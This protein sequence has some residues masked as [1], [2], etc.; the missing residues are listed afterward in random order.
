MESDELQVV[1]FDVTAQDC[2]S[3]SSLDRVRGIVPS[4]VAVLQHWSSGLP[5][6]LLAV[7]CEEGEVYLIRHALVSE[8][9]MA[10]RVDLD[11]FFANE[12]LPPDCAAVA[13]RHVA[14]GV[15]EHMR[16]CNF[17]YFPHEFFAVGYAAGPVVVYRVKGSAGRVLTK[18]HVVPEQS[19]PLALH[20]VT[21]HRLV[22]A[23]P[24]RV[25][26]IEISV[27]NELVEAHVVSSKSF[28]GSSFLWLG[29]R[30]HL[31]SFALHNAVNGAV[32]LRS[33]AHAERQFEF[34]AP[35]VIIGASAN[36]P[37]HVLA[38]DVSLVSSDF[39]AV[40]VAGKDGRVVRAHAFGA[41]PRLLREAL[42]AGRM[43][44]EPPLSHALCK[45]A[46]AA[47]F[48]GL[49]AIAGATDDEAAESIME[50]CLEKD[51][52]GVLQDVFH[53]DGVSAR[54]THV[55][56]WTR[57][58]AAALLDPPAHPAPVA[59]ADTPVA[60][61]EAKLALLGS[62]YRLQEFL[63]ETTQGLGEP[64]RLEAERAAGKTLAHALRL[65]VV[66]ALRVSHLSVLDAAQ[67][68]VQMLDAS[69]R[70]QRK[71]LGANEYLFGDYLWHMMNTG[72]GRPDGSHLWPPRSFDAILS[73]MAASPVLQWVKQ[74]VLLYALLDAA[75]EGSA[76]ELV[77]RNAS[78]VISNLGMA[79]HLRRRVRAL[80]MVDRN[81]DASRAASELASVGCGELGG[82]ESLGVVAAKRL[83]H[84]AHQRAALCVLRSLPGLP[85]SSDE[86][87]IYFEAYLA[88]GLVH[89][90]LSLCR[91]LDTLA[92]YLLFFAACDRR[93]S[94][95]LVARLSL[96]QREEDAFFSFVGA[97][98]SDAGRE[99]RDLLV[100][101][102]LL[103]ERVLQ[104]AT[105]WQRIQANVA[106][107]AARQ[108]EVMLATRIVDVPDCVAHPSQAP[109]SL[110][111]SSFDPPVLALPEA[112]LAHQQPPQAMDVGDDDFEESPPI[113]QQL[114]PRATST[115]YNVPLSTPIKSIRRR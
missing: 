4:H 17:A 112:A 38:A 96:S 73:L 111:A 82:N 19:S 105:L 81:L 80:W 43:A 26:L 69:C 11:A 14:A 97:L 47:D 115:I 79:A 101:Y 60:A 29:G 39:V 77:E 21:P 24:Q 34:G 36:A 93:G 35:H 110:S 107:P 52:L 20:F 88:N 12:F 59:E 102:L 95:G 22:V 33:E 87:E 16:V 48:I 41:G 99:C 25:E 5:W 86:A 9:T 31:L 83:L 40:S 62:L 8:G 37:S 44:L 58:Y 15:G 30:D 109:S 10:M 61:L 64:L 76:T 84:H 28:D 63:A 90:C 45:Q 56:E 89:Q 27:H 13:V 51:C 53:A 108:I 91:S 57:R 54:A 71:A 100:I 94:L 85:K 1:L 104:A 23:R 7:G 50:V 98:A 65:E 55:R 72:S 46:V 3:S 18:H 92:A 2:V 70:A 42:V 106:P 49:E 113:T 114:H 6:V 74:A 78:K 103:R 67:F 32:A 75:H 66:L 68:P